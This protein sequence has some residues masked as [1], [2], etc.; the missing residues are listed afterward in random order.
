MRLADALDS[1]ERR[2]TLAT[3]QT[4]GHRAVAAQP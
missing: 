3:A 4:G 2:A 1:A